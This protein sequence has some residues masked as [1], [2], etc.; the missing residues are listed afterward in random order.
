MYVSVNLI[1]FGVIVVGVGR[2]IRDVR[3]QHYENM[4]HV[5]F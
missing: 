1:Y 5:I 4:N 3:T 2:G